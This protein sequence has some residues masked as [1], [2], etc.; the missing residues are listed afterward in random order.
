MIDKSITDTK[1]EWEISVPIFRNPIIMK[2]LGIAIGIPFGLLLIFLVIAKAFYGAL[3]VS[4][5]IL[6]T[7]LFVLIF[8]G[9]KYQV[10][11]VLDQNGIRCFTQKDQA[12]KN[13]IINTITIALGFLSGK[14]TVAGS[15]ILAQSRQDLMISWKNI[16]KVKYLK[17]K[18]IVMVKGGF[19]ENIAVFCTSSNFDAAETFIRNYRKQ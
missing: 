15:G 4:A 3:L 11:F 16:R 1:M 14:P 6:L 5:L 9:G 18:N 8:W 13:L 12:K 19:T 7:I 2:Q 17:S 10:G